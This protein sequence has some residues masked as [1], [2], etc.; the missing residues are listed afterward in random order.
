MFLNLPERMDASMLAK[1]DLGSSDAVKDKLLQDCYCDIPPIQTFLQDRHS[2]LVGAKGSGK[3]AV[4]TLLKN[5]HLKFEGRKKEDTLIITIDEPIE[6]A[7][8]AIVIEEGLK[9]KIRDHVVRYQFLW[10]VYVLY[11][12]CLAL[13]KRDDMRSVKD[14]IEGL[15]SLFSFEQKQPSLLQ[16][17]TAIKGT[18]GFKIN[19]SNPAFPAPDFYISAEP[20]ATEDSSGKVSSTIDIEKYKEELNSALVKEG[21]TVYIL[22]DNLDD[23]VAKDKYATQKA[24][25]QA[26]LNCCR[27][28]SRFPALRVKV[29]LR[30][31]LF[32]RMDFSQLG[33]YDKIVPDMIEL[34]WTDADIRYFISRRL[35]FN[36]NKG[37]R[38]RRF[39]IYVDEKALY[40]DPPESKRIIWQ[41]WLYR[42]YR[43]I[44][45]WMIHDHSAARNITVRDEISRQ[46]IL[47]VFPRDVL[48]RTN[49][50]TKQKH[51]LFSYLASHFDL[52]DGHTTPRIILLFLLN[53]VAVSRTYYQEN[54]D[55]SILTLTNK[56]E[57]PLF[58]REHF[59]LAYAGLQKSML[60]IF[61][62][63]MT[64][65][66]WQSRT[67]IFFLRKGK[68]MTFTFQSLCKMVG[69][70][71]EGEC[72]EYLAYLS[73]L[74]VLRCKNSDAAHKD[75]A[76]ALPL[77]LQN[78]WDE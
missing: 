15:C 25:L 13:S 38:L 37:W 18:V 22:V 7:T 28:Y 11:R 20:A 64:L 45:S 66:D 27:N 52:G 4:F 23:F 53:L 61:K 16:F 39:K 17:M 73:H 35:I 70:D 51:E 49:S 57:F 2:I 69:L 48:H 65:P 24:I 33:G 54:P 36:L 8:A 1:F 75:R 43:F 6:Y 40:L 67:E 46:I 55:E 10:E 62:S 76:Y 68:K 26:I 47:S 77:L 30:S 19:M 56:K 58:K 12:I 32:H 34:V 50:G 74:G 60:E 71:D 31:D 3:T 29:S 5:K 72:K 42:F 41:R 44:K 9:S 59:L 21:L 14:K 78:I 63:C